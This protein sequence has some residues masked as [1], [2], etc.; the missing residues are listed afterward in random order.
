MDEYEPL[1]FTCNWN[2]KLECTKAFT[3]LRMSDRFIVGQR[4][5]VYLK[6]LYKFDVRV[7]QKRLIMIRDLSEGICW[8]DTGFSKRE[9][10]EIILN[11]HKR[12][13]L[14]D[15]GFINWYLLTRWKS[16]QMELEL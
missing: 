8:L 12:Q 3:T 14:T 7:E 11:M 4:L 9:T 16:E 5:S 6:G 15:S 10:I 2:N 13:A 1:S